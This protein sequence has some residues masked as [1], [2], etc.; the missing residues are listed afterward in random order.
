MGNYVTT[1]DLYAE[2]VPTTISS[3]LLERRIAKWEEI[4]EKLTGQLFRVVTPGEIIF[5]GN[6]THLMHFNLPIIAVTSLKING[7]TST[8]LA[9]EY[10]AH[11]GRVS[12]KDDRTNPKIELLGNQSTSIYTVSGSSVF[13]KGADQAI[14]ATWGYLDE[15]DACPAPVKDA[16]IELIALDTDGYWDKGQN[17]AGASV[18]PTVR[19][20]TDG[21]EI[22]Y[23]KTEN[24][25]MTWMMLPV[26][27]QHT[28]A[29]YRK[30]WSI[31]VPDARIGLSYY[32]S[33]VYGW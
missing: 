31:A 10:R 7:S 26:T 30:P 28:L 33:F 9:S 32:D 4:V 29:M 19:E 8:L 11:V 18:T 12:P 5:D 24:I 2:G 15:N 17:A 6:N 13:A 3:T 14:T 16:I 27:I 25:R 22:E 1:A 20:R 23:Q 21:H